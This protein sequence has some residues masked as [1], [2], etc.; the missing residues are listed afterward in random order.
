MKIIE[1]D[2]YKDGGTI[3]IDT[4]RGEYCIDCRLG[5]ITKGSIFCNYPKDDNSNIAPEQDK[6]KQEL[7][8]AIVKY[9]VSEG[10]FDWTPRVME[11]L[12]VL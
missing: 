8:D 5:T 7:A 2:G 6:V 11:L 9:T 12:N 4:T 3:K 1:I 10:N